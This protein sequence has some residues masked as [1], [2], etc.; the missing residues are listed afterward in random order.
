MSRGPEVDGSAVHRA[1]ICI[2][3]D[4]QHAEPT[5]PRG[6]TYQT[7]SPTCKSRHVRGQSAHAKIDRESARNRALPSGRREATVD[8]AGLVLLPVGAPHMRSKRELRGACNARKGEASAPMTVETGNSQANEAAA[9]YCGVPFSRVRSTC[10]Q[11]MREHSSAAGGQS[12]S[13]Q[14]RA[15]KS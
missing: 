7:R 3:H 13:G 4:H 11:D 1:I 8:G 14:T 2:Q 5:T 15:R 9:R 12:K 6:S 10:G